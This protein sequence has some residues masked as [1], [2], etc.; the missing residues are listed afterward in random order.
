MSEIEESESTGEAGRPIDIEDQ[1]QETDTGEEP[2]STEM[3]DTDDESNPGPV[4]IG[5]REATQKAGETP[6]EIL[7]DTTSDTSSDNRR[8][9]NS[10]KSIE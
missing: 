7:D 6:T 8:E 4:G 1:G 3:S 10:R 5:L 2:N 9:F